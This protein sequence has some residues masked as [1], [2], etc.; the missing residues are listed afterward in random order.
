MGTRVQLVMVGPNKGCNKEFKGV[1]FVNGSAWVQGPDDQIMHILKYLK[2]FGA[3]PATEAKEA[4]LEVDKYLASKGDSSAL[5]KQKADLK[6]QLAALEAAE[7]EATPKVEAK[8]EVVSEEP[9]PAEE[10]EDGRVQDSE[11]PE[12]RSGQQSHGGKNSGKG[13]KNR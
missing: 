4:Q 10:K 12:G 6:M 5:L 9:P 1:P 3:Y 7:A 13:R 2:T 11:A 8:V